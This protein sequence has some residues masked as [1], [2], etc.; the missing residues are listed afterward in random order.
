MNDI[1]RSIKIESLKRYETL[2]AKYSGRS[3]RI[4]SG[5]WGAW[6]RENGGGYAD[7][8]AL[9]GVF[10]FDDAYRRTSHVGR[11]KMICIEVLR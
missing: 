1:E 9:A 7:N 4:R 8:V 3:V 5:Q 10:T 11:E 2:R 6:W